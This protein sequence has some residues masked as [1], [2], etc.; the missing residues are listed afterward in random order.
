MQLKAGERLGSTV[1]STEVVVVRAPAEAV[2]LRCGG[3]P[4][5]ALADRG[6]PSAKLAPHLA[7]GTQ[8][9]KRYESEDVGLEL[10]CTKAGTGSLSVGDRVLAI[11]GVKP[12]PSSD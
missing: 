2:D 4:M 8:L 10:L 3:E 11:R 12:L 6:S 5:V 7:G 9:G 1:D